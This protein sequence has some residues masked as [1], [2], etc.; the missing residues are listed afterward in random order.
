MGNICNTICNPNIFKAT[1]SSSNSQINASTSNHKN[2]LIQYEIRENLKIKTGAHFKD[3]RLTRQRSGANIFTP[4]RSRENI[5][6]L[7]LFDKLPIGEGNFGQ[8]RRAVL[9]RNKNREF[10]V[11]MINKDIHIHDLTLFLKEIEMLKTKCL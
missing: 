6:K 5:K 9:K 8:V 7:Y 1:K 3:R 10:A 4:T 2:S 11:K